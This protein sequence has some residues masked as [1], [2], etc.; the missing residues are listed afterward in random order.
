MV[1][2]TVSLPKE[3]VVGERPMVPVTPVPPK[4][5]ACGLPAVAELSAIFSEATRLPEAVGVK[6][7]VMVQLAPEATEVPQVLV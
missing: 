5:T 6:V 2:L 4:L 7:T 3:T 1:L